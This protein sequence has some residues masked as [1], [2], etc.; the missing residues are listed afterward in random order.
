MKVIIFPLELLKVKAL[1][2]LNETVNI[3]HIHNTHMNTM[4][5][6]KILIKAV[7]STTKDLIRFSGELSDQGKDDDN[8]Y[9]PY[10]AKYKALI[11]HYLL[12]N[13]VS[14]RELAFEWKPDSDYS[15]SNL[16][17]IDL[18]YSDSK[19]KCNVLI[20]VKQ[21][22]GLNRSG[23]DIRY[24]DYRTKRNGKVVSGIIYDVIKLHNACKG[25]KDGYENKGIMLM[26][27]AE[28]KIEDNLDLSIIKGSVLNQVKQEINK[29]P[30]NVELLWTSKR[31]T[32]YIS[33]D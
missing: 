12:T 16:K 19:K 6:R 21:V 17:H 11:Y 14:Y 31:R 13:G 3:E 33:L 8:N 18:W 23:I 9:F 2:S 32:E 15:K 28:P 7:E 1:E 10:E 5:F 20:E 30:K 27:L 25:N 22:Y 24:T 29:K 4:A 26:Y